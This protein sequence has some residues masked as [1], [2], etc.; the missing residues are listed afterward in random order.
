M[1]GIP[2]IP[3]FTLFFAKTSGLGRLGAKGECGA[4][5]AA[6]WRMGRPGLGDWDCEWDCA[7]AAVPAA[8]ARLLLCKGDDD[9]D[10]D[11]I[12]FSASS[13]SSAA[14]CLRANSG[15]EPFVEPH[16]RIRLNFRS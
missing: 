13:S 10:C 14:V 3:V 16:F 11:G 12:L 9:S 15:L 1:Y 2:Y 8:G 5:A 6:V 4:A 7:R